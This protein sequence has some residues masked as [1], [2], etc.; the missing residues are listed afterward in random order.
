METILRAV[1]RSGHVVL[2]DDRVNLPDGTELA[3]ELREAV[4]PYA[5][6]EHT[7]L[8]ADRDA[9]RRAEQARL[10]GNF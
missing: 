3:L 8:D 10:R 7:E 1:V 4:D 6:D 5:P 2:I 9:E